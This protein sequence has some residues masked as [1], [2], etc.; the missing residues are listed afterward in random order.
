M[1]WARLGAKRLRLQQAGSRLLIA[2]SL[3]GR[4]KHL[5]ES[6]ACHALQY[7]SERLVSFVFMAWALVAKTSSREL[8]I[9]EKT[10]D[11][12]SVK[13]K[14]VQLE[15]ANAQLKNEVEQR[16]HHVCLWEHR[17]EA[18]AELALRISNTHANARLIFN[19]FMALRSVTRWQTR[20][21]AAV[22]RS[23]NERVF[24]LLSDVL[25]QWVRV[26]VSSQ[27]H[28][29]TESLEMERSS[30]NTLAQWHAAARHEQ[31]ACRASV[32]HIA[33][34]LSQLGHDCKYEFTALPLILSQLTEDHRSHLINYHEQLERVRLR[35]DARS[36][37]LERWF[38]TR[39]IKRAMQ[40]GLIAWAQIC[41]QSQQSK[42]V[43]MLQRS[44]NNWRQVSAGQ[45][46]APTD[47]RTRTHQHT[48]AAHAHAHAHTHRSRMTVTEIVNSLYVR[49]VDWRWNWMHR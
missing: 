39:Q 9:A 44:F 7:S 40:L 19:C 15:S 36:D 4:C 11:H 6:L 32:H 23:H 10:A 42:R 46:T 13:A 37:L 25:Q 27:V 28:T 47:V 38:E 34:A 29:C 31:E 20:C 41:K 49:A 21:V 8:A 5:K 2:V 14:V 3:I 45:Q 22:Q 26:A 30:V 1:M 24:F 18:A 48:F 35:L 17:H 33:A 43:I 12:L 16:E